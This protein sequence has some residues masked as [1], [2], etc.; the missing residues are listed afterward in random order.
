MF[1][2]GSGPPKDTGLHRYVFL[3][4]R[5]NGKIHD[6]E[7]GHLTNRSGCRL[8]S[9]LNFKIKAWNSYKNNSK[10]DKRGCW[11]V[12]EFAKKH[13]LGDPIAGNFYQA[14]V[15]L[16]YHF[17]FDFRQSMTTMCRCFI[18]NWAAELI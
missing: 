1:L 11:K 16:K 17:Q 10:G 6:S 14:I 5:Q 9:I 3:V 4:Y 18:S 15:L 7:H 2:V 13:G 8:K 12:H